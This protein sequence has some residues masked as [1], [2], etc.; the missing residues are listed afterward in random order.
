MATQEAMSAEH[1]P[2]FTPSEQALLE[3]LDPEYVSREDVQEA[4]RRKNGFDAYMRRASMDSPTGEP[5]AFQ[6]S[7]DLNGVG[8]S[9]MSGSGTD[10]IEGGFVFGPILAALAAPLINSAVGAISNAVRGRGGEV[11]MGGAAALKESWN[12]RMD[13]L[14]DIE[15]E[16]EE[17]GGRDFWLLLHGF[18]KNE[19]ET[20]LPKI[21]DISSE[22]ARPIA[23]MSTSHVFPDDFAEL[24]RS[25]KDKE[26]SGLCRA[27]SIGGIM[28]PLAHYALRELYDSPKDADRIYNKIVARGAFNDENV[29]AAMGISPPQ[30]RGGSKAGWR[31]FW[32]G[33]KNV[34]SKI[35]NGAK[36]V[37]GFILPSIANVAPQLINSA[38]D[39]ASSRF[40]FSPGVSDA[41][42][43]VANTVVSIPHQLQEGST[44]RDVAQ[45]MI[46]PAAQLGQEVAPKLISKIK[47]KKVRD[48]ASKAIEIGMDQLRGPV[49]REEE[50]ERGA[51][52][53]PFN[54][55][56][57]TTASGRRGRGRPRGSKNK[58]KRGGKLS[59]QITPV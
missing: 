16:L 56:G 19:V 3:T 1:F 43:N 52:S 47:N 55:P 53:P 46:A 4:V 22:L 21:S 49:V 28:A 59:F 50:E 41:I 18:V 51:E 34:G 32:R 14:A 20:L 39:T 11:K 26:G 23:V 5:T 24:M 44:M 12:S 13:E 31:K 6:M 57:A 17:T 7:S 38:V 58:A 36:K 2:Y 54:S 45:N 25:Y 40:N 33:V 27:G 15:D 35:W 37:L 29:Y 9:V 42:K 10:A 30:M 8:S 48:A